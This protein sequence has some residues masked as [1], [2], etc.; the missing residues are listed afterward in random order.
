[1]S[2]SLIHIVLGKANPERMNGVNKVVYALATEQAQAGW[3]VAVWGVTANP[4]VNYPKR[5]FPTRLFKAHRN[6]F[7]LDKELEKAIAA[8]TPETVVH[9][10][11]GFIPLN[12]AVAHHLR[13]NKIPYILTPHGSYNVIAMDKNRT[14]KET[15]VRFFERTL[16]R[17]AA[18][19][20]CLGQ[21]EVAGTQLLLPTAATQLLP[22]GFE[23]PAAA[24]PAR[25]EVGLTFRVGFCGRLDAYTKGLDALLTGF[26]LFLQQVP[27]A[28]LWLIGDGPDRDRLEAAAAALPTGSTTFFG[29]QYGNEKLAL[30]AQ[31]D[32]FA[33][34]S[35]NEGLP[36]AVLE[37]AAL[38]VPCLVTEATNLGAY[39]QQFACGEVIATTDPQ[40][41]AAG[42][43]ALHRVTVSTGRHRMQDQARAMVETA[44]C[45]SALLPAY[46]AM[47]AAAR[48]PALVYA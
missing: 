43:G 3:D 28:E 46:R 13:K 47:Y 14:A 29:S 11:G 48:R 32:V 23:V 40:Q 9:L 1:M 34:P 44:F 33:H 16:L 27:Q 12:Y 2:T 15:Y 37:A 7:A 38:G 31:I 24:L 41:V 21:S 17:H 18:Q 8:L 36:T 5:A 26:G 30:L 19:I 4:I 45:W 22:Y 10:H 25:S 35:R 6:P 39:V 42:L 20:H